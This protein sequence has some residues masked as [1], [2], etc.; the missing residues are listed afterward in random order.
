MK[1]NEFMKMLSPSTKVVLRD[2]EEE[3]LQITYPREFELYK[4]YK[5]CK[6]FH[7]KPGARGVVIYIDKEIKE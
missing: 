3:L 5:D 6:M 4:R 7:V 2:T 1:L